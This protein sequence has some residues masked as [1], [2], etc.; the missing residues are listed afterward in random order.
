MSNRIALWRDAPD[1][2]AAA[3]LAALLDWA[4]VIIE[5]PDGAGRS[6]FFAACSAAFGFPE[7]FGANWDAFEECLI[8]QEFDEVEDLD[9]AEGLL[10]L[11][12]GWG[13]LAESEPEHFAIAIEVFRD[14]L[15]AWA[16]E[17]LAARVVLI[18]D[19][20]E[21]SLHHS[22]ANAEG[23]FVEAEEEFVDEGADALEGGLGQR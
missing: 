8:S 14:V 17:E 9:D 2:D 6:G 15:E 10:I 5:V 16:E 11:W 1:P 22:R 18:G 23:L 4:S 12:S 20:P 21:L 19:G 7:Y 3:E 13:D